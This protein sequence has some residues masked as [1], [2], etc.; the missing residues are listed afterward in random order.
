VIAADGHTYE[1]SYLEAW[2]ATGKSTSPVTNA[3]L[4]HALL[5]P[6]HSMRSMVA[7]FL[8]AAAR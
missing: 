4:A 8:D 3:P 6:N 1:R 5:V 7:A 2:L